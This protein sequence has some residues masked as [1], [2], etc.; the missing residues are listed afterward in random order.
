MDMSHG[1]PTKNKNMNISCHM[2]CMTNKYQQTL[3]S[4]D[5][6]CSTMGDSLRVVLVDGLLESP[7]TS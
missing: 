6:S 5:L 4:P 7:K 2:S 3:I 1:R